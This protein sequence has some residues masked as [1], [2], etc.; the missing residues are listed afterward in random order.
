[1][2]QQSDHPF[3]SIIMP[4]YNRALLLPKAIESVLA[5]DWSS[6]EL[7]VIDDG[8][9]DDSAAVIQRFSDTRIRYFYQ[10][11]SERS[12]ARNNGIDR[13]RGNF[14]CFIDSDDYYL[15]EHLSVLHKAIMA[16]DGLPALYYTS[17][18][19]ENN[20]ARKLAKGFS[21]LR[22]KGLYN[23]MNEELLQTN[24]VC[25]ARSLLD[26]NRFPPQF[27]LF[28]D[29]HLWFRVIAA[30]EMI[31]IDTPTTVMCD[32]EG[33]SL[34]VSKTAFREKVSKYEAVLDDLLFRKKFP[35]LD[36][37]VPDTE[38][39]R[40]VAAKLLVMCYEALHLGMTG[41]AYQL[42]LRSMTRYFDG[43]RIAEY[44]KLLFGIPVFTTFMRKR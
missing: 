21:A 26:D 27:N 33:R 40:F 37:L 25:I 20:G 1:M 43:K 41:F 17:Y 34:H 4:V 11:N 42:L 44:A 38:K 5:Q 14:V 10:Q 30:S 6:W 9:T 15:P 29:N 24:S 2:E 19:F 23:I 8:S 18:F 16:N 3:F 7:I 31:F 28:E 12:T 36:A 35:Q 32:H 22:N 13:A 39:R